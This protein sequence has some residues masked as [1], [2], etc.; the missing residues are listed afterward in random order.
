MDL[1]RP[2]RASEAPERT[3]P[4]TYPEPFASRMLG[5][6]KRPL[7]ELFALRNFGVNLTTLQPGAV[8]ALHHA[9]SKQDEFVYIVSGHPTLFL[10]DES[11]E[12]EPGM[13]VGFP[14]GGAAH[15]LANNTQAPVTYL[16][17]GDRSA[18]DLCS[19]PDDDL[20]AEGHE[21]GWVFKHKDGTPY[22]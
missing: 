19:Y 22:A 10:A 4:S 8:S 17:I 18:A 9:H 21:G 16:E 15:H 14:A 12:M 13:A 7:G 6:L 11:M 5:R 2:I 20:V 3:K 1:R